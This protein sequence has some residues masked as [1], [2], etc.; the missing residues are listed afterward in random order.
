MPRLLWESKPAHAA[1][2]VPVPSTMQASQDAF[3]D[4]VYIAYGYPSYAY[5]RWQARY[6][7]L[8][9]RSRCQLIADWERN[10]ATLEA[11]K[12]AATMVA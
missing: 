4:L 5:E 7:A 11:A 8:P 1:M 2:T 10:G 6:F 12:T 9:L 3:L